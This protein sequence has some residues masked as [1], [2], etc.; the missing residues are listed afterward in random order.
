MLRKDMTTLL[1]VNA[2]L[3]PPLRPSYLQ[4]SADASLA[5]FQGVT[6]HTIAAIL[7]DAG[8]C[9]DQRELQESYHSKQLRPGCP[10]MK[11]VGIRSE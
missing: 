4:T 2:G 1:I 5:H 9:I 11:P 3:Q 8:A 6:D 10:A 7:L